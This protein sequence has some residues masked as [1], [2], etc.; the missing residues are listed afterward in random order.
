MLRKL[1]LSLVLIAPAM[2]QADL[3]QGLKFYKNKDYDKAKTEFESLLPL[4]NS[5]A[6]F[7]LAVMAMYG[8]GEPQDLVRAYAYFSLA[9][10]LKQSGTDKAL[11]HIETLI[12][13]EQ[14]QQAMLLLAQIQNNTIPPYSANE[15]D[16]R[17]LSP[18]RI[19]D[20]RTEPD[21]PIGAAKR[22]ISGFSVV[23]FVIDKEGEVVFAQT[24][25]GLPE[26]VFAKAS[27]KAIRK[28]KFKPGPAASIQT[29]RLDYNMR[30]LTDT[31]GAE[32]P[33]VKLINSLQQYAWPAA[34]NGSA[35][36]QYHAAAVFDYLQTEDDVYATTSTVAVQ[37]PTLADLATTKTGFGLPMQ[38]FSGK[39]LI[40]VNADLQIET[41]QPLL[42][43]V[44]ALL[45]TIIPG[46]PQGS[47][48]IE[49]F[50]EYFGSGK[51]QSFATDKMYVK[52][53][54]ALP[55]E[56][57]SSYWL[58]QAARNGMTTAQK[59]RAMQQPYWA[60]YLQQQKE[61]T[62]LG[63]HAIELMTQNSPQAKAALAIAKE[64]GFKTTSELEEL[65]Q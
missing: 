43:T 31:D 35:E 3:L 37:P 58:D 57:T 24:Q 17:P 47:Y 18:L 8:Q 4:G 33:A 20:K 60:S 5:G 55:Q 41:V 27:V 29:V 1:L 56:W 65:F 40:Q 61:P 59:V 48:R 26:E 28:W 14:K 6:A 46:L 44:P 11:Q 62:A 49:P 64:A 15:P 38:A 10:Y 53:L 32:V 45:G 30:P 22:G 19:A 50:D 42:G 2:T 21:Y 63:W 12:T 16:P 34:L 51:P 39:A 7:N 36:H 9:N 54:H 13:P 52:P 23:Q 25:R